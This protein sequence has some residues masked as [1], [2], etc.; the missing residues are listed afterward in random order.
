M[1]EGIPKGLPNRMAPKMEIK[2]I[3]EPKYLG[4]LINSIVLPD[5]PEVIKQ[6]DNV[7]VV[8][9]GATWQRSVPHL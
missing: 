9:D 1:Y 4:E 6:H 5:H 3:E 8:G 2:Q 7:I